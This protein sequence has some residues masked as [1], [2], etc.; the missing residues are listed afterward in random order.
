MELWDAYTA[1][2]LRTGE[3]LVRDGLIPEGLYHMV[4]E[5]LVRHRDGSFLAMRRARSKAGFPGFWETTA[6][7]SALQSEDALQCAERE[8]REETGL[9]CGEFTRI[10]YEVFAPTHCLYHSF[11][12]TVDCDKA[13]VRLQPGETEDYRWMT[14]REFA[15]FVNSD[16]MIPSQKRRL[17]RYLLDAGYLQEPELTPAKLV[18]GGICP[19]CYDRA[20][21]FCLYGDPAE[22]RLYENELF[23]CSLIGA[24]RAPGHAVIISKEH[25][26]DM[27]DIPDDL[28]AAVYLFAKKAMNA[29]KAVYGAESV[30]L[31]TMCDGPMNHFHVQLIPRYACEKRGSKN[32]VKPRQAYQEDQEKTEKLRELLKEGE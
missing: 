21:G 16:D 20:N 4:C 1:E 14:E 24:P 28:C 12:C 18:D 2:G 8:L 27:L 11:L 5:V 15:D 26:K 25:F 9:T 32:F 6:G 17:S 31:C 30:Y 22:K 3:T 13:S 23:E 19:T 29:I 7:G 10:G